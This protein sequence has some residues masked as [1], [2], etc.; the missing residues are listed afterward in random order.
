MAIT[1]AP[2]GVATGE[3]KI[4]YQDKFRKEKSVTYPILLAA[5]TADI[6]AVLTA[7]D[8]ITNCQL[9]EVFVNGVE[10]DITGEATPAQTPDFNSVTELVNVTFFSA[11]NCHDEL[12]V[13]VPAPIAGMF[14]G[15]EQRL[16]NTAYAAFAT[17]A[18]ALAAILIDPRTG[19]SDFV[20]EGGVRTQ[21]ALTRPTGL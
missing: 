16:V 3:L 15:I 10:Q 9:C 20:V 17:W 6:E 7:V 4:R 12:T 1:I 11:S 21:Q 19:L 8:A 18:S 14:T 5:V 13:V 2:S